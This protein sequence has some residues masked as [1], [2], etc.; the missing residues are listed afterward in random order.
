[1]VCCMPSSSPIIHP[2]FFHSSPALLIAA[3]DVRV[4]E[5]R[6]AQSRI[7]IKLTKRRAEDPP[8]P[9]T[10]RG[11]VDPSVASPWIVIYDDDVFYVWIKFPRGDGFD[12]T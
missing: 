5:D 3:R 9:W 10:V 2:S 7:N 1:M 4:M 11:C 6:T 12:P 8:V